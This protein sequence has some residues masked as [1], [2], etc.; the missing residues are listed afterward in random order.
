MSLTR[1]L[2]DNEVGPEVEQIFADIRASFDLPFVPTPFRVLAGVPEYLRLMWRDLGH[3]AASREF[4]SAAVA[5]QEFVRSEAI[6]GGWRFADQERVLAGQKISSEDT[7]VLS[8]VVGIFNR[9]LPALTLFLRLMQLGYSGGIG[10]RVTPGKLSPALSRLITLNVPNEREA[11][12]RVWL[13]YGDIKRTTGEKHVL[14]LFRVLSPF[15]GYLASAWM[16]TKRLFKD[17]SFQNAREEV[18]RRA[19]SCVA[20][21]PVHDHRELARHITAEQWSE[22]E[23]TVDGYV[24]LLPLYALLTATWRRSFAVEQTVIRAAS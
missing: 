17:Q 22:I 6:T 20:G 15:P 3:V 5:L 23:K 1:T 18:A 24:R 4:R 2:E 21:I 11:G 12:L 10:G 14:D 9:A 13:L 7:L 19:A 16:D 8:G